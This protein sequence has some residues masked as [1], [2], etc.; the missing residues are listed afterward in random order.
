MKKINKI[1]S[2]ALVLAAS[3]SLFAAGNAPVQRIDV[4][5]LLSSGGTSPGDSTLTAVEVSFDNGGAEPCM[6]ATLAFQGEITVYA[7][8]DEECVAPIS[9]VTVTPIA[10]P[11]GLVYQ[12]PAA[13]TVIS[14]GYYATQMVVN[15]S[16]PPVFDSANGAL[17]TPGKAG[18]SATSYVTKP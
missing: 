10:G 5:N 1:L 3:G 9:L 16:S 7:G 15:Q 18:V 17:L 12:A 2:A 6:T 4:V 8:A 13:P 11:L 14:R